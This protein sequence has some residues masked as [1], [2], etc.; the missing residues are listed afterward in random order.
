MRVIAGAVLILLGLLFLFDSLNWYDFGELVATFWPLILVV[1]GLWMVLQR[2]HSK[3]D[4][5]WKSFVD[6]RHSKSL[7]DLKLR[8]TE[9]P[10]PGLEIK[11]GMGDLKVDLS[12]ATLK[13]GE[14]LV[15]CSLGAGDMEITLPVNIPVKAVCN[16]G[17][18]DIYLLGQ[19][20]DGF[21]QS[22]QHQDEGYD[23][24]A[25]KITLNLKVGLGD[26]KV[27]HA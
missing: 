23:A 21:G 8:P 18:G 9:L 14:N 10:S 15:T 4:Q 13:Q 22:L 24:A 2:Y 12:S 3:E 1:V 27:A 25:Q 17:A 11:H 26:C 6:S 7:G 20:A 19:H 16:V 5:N